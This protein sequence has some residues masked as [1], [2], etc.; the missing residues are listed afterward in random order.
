MPGRQR[1]VVRKVAALEQKARVTLTELYALMP[2][3]YRE[4]LLANH[5]L[6]LQLPC[7]AWGDAWAGASEAHTGLAALHKLLE[8]R[9]A[10]LPHPPECPFVESSCN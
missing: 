6:A 3:L 4:R 10:A 8:E 9:A 7:A 5:P 2:E 1:A